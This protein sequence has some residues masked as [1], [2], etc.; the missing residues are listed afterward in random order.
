MNQEQ[1]SQD[2]V[3]DQGPTGQDKAGFSSRTYA[4]RTREVLEQQFKEATKVQADTKAALLEVWKDFRADLN[5]QWSNLNDSAKQRT[6]SIRE[7]FVGAAKSDATDDKTD[8]PPS[9]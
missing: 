2:A 7:R 1:Y 5:Q 8:T 3:N 9:A 4:K 6:K